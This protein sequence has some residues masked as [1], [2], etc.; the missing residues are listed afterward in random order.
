[1]D[2]RGAEISDAEKLT[3]RDMIEAAKKGDSD[4]VNSVLPEVCNKYIFVQWAIDAGL[5]SDDEKVKDLGASILEITE[6]EYDDELKA[7]ATNGLVVLMKEES[8]FGF[9]AACIL[10]NNEQ[11]VIE[12]LK[13]EVI[14]KTRGQL[15]RI[16]ED[17]EG[18]EEFK[19][20]AEE[21]LG[22]LNEKLSGGQ[23]G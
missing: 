6:Y 2:E 7:E 16:L 8:I 15:N 21:H 5:T 20:I 10:V 14:E 22:Q 18:S 9:R 23:E 1:M 19:Q 3:V 4:F 12:E 13:S 17:Q 11:F